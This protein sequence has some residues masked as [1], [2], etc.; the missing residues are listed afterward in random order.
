M[1]EFAGQLHMLLQDDLLFQHSLVRG[2]A[3]G[4]VFTAPSPFLDSPIDGIQAAESLGR[5]WLT[6]LHYVDSEIP[7]RYSAE[8]SLEEMQLTVP[9]DPGTNFVLRPAIA[10]VSGHPAVLYF[11][12][13]NGGPFELVFARYI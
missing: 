8:D 10:D 13:N 12:D 4:N 11:D 5:L 1:F 7:C 9:V 2:Q 6:Y 3:G